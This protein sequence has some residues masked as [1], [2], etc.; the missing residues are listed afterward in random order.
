LRQHSVLLQ[1]AG[2]SRRKIRWRQV[3]EK[4][5]APWKKTAGGGFWTKSEAYGGG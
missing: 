2:S 4:P 3:E 1:Q 5:V